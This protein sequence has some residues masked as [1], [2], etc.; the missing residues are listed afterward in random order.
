MKRLIFRNEQEMLNELRGGRFVEN[1]TSF[2]IYDEMFDEFIT[3]DK[4]SRVITSYGFEG[5]IY[6]Y[7]ERGL[8]KVSDL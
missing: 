7:I 5:L 1:E 3:V 6:Q 2:D 4:N 8:L